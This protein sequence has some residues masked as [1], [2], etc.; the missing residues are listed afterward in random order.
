MDVDWIN[1]APNQI[2][3]TAHYLM[4]AHRG[5]NLRLT[6]Y[7]VVRAESVQRRHTRIWGPF[8]DVLLHLD[9]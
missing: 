5:S 7:G 3:T 8:L 4:E 6:G 9:L 2:P 1:R